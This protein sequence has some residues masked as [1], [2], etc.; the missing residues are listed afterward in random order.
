M[1]HFI[2][3]IAN[4]NLRSTHSFEIFFKFK[5]MLCFVP[6]SDKQLYLKKPFYALERCDIE[7]IYA[8]YVTKKKS[9]VS[10]KK[11]PFESTSLTHT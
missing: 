3:T 5:V 9:M 6:K 1:I 11:Q 7:H 10:K 4:N 8:F 2:V